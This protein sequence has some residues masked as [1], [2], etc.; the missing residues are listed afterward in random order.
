[1]KQQLL[2]LVTSTWLA[3]CAIACRVEWILSGTYRLV[4]FDSS[5]S[6]CRKFSTS[7]LLKGRCVYA[8]L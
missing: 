4:H 7:V 8:G 6:L 3:L 5:G 1:M 2:L